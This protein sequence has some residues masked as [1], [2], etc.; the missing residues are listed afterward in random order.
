MGLRDKKRIEGDDGVSRDDLTYEAVVGSLLDPIYRFYRRRV[1]PD[2]CDDLTV[3]TFA[4]VFSRLP[5]Y[6]AE[7]G[8]LRPWV[9]GIAANILRHHWRDEQ[10]RLGR[11]PSLAVWPLRIPVPKTQAMATLSLMSRLLALF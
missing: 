3:E 1:G 7:R 2:I 5:S 9:F 6:S 10:A 11:R 4:V 8:A